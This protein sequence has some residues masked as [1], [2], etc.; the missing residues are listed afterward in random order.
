[1]AMREHEWPAGDA[2]ADWA[3]EKFYV[4]IEK[5]RGKS[6]T[7][8]FLD[9]FAGFLVTMCFGILASLF[10]RVSV[11]RPEVFQRCFANACQPG[12][13]PLIVCW[14]HRTLI[15]SLIF[16][17]AFYWPGFLWTWIR[18]VN[19]LPYHTANAWNYH[20]TAFRRFCTRHWHVLP[21]LRRSDSHLVRR[22]LRILR[23]SRYPVLHMFPQGQRVRN[24]D[25]LVA[26]K[27]G[28]GSIACAAQA[29][30]LP[31]WMRGTEKVQDPSIPG[32][33]IF[34]IKFP[35]R[36]WPIEIRVGD[37]MEFDP[38]RRDYQN[39]SDEILAAIIALNPSTR[40]S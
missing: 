6:K 9:E 1:M 39:V 25:Q 20:R 2:R 13:R 29:T 21:V 34:R 37:P 23:T 28:I 7:Q 19:P 31:M 4:P 3:A 32:H 14:N 26:A 8:G 35:G 12:G 18:G 11:D 33:H 10:F 16:V 24:D 36:R 30:V 5:I 22:V 15:D 27:P 40:S 17:Q 38:T